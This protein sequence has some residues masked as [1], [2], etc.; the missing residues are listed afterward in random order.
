MIK[1][2]VQ[3]TVEYYLG[4]NQMHLVC[5]TNPLTHL[6][7]TLQGANKQIK[8][9]VY[10]IDNAAVLNVLRLKAFSDRVPV[11]MIID[12]NNLLGPSCVEQNGLL[13][14]MVEIAEFQRSVNEDIRSFE[15]RSCQPVST[16]KSGFRSL[17]AKCF[18]VDSD[19]YVGGS[20]NPTNNAMENN[21]E[22]L[23]VIEDRA[24]CRK[25]AAWF[26]RLWEES[27]LVTTK[28]IDEIAEKLK[29]LKEEK[30]AKKEMERRSAM[31]KPQ[32]KKQ[33][34]RKYMKEQ[35][36]T[37]AEYSYGAAG[38]TANAGYEQRLP[39]LI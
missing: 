28:E 31:P 20:L 14:E 8:A 11:R 25:V 27:R 21:E 37:P 39:G 36:S 32:P 33:P 17:H 2:Q 35:K 3:D 10:S 7:Y 19:I 24:E 12:R 23:V 22:H 5:I 34:K 6:A 30:A 13:R 18:R 9:T 1:P 15:L 26:E 4:A 29:K 38:A 16:G